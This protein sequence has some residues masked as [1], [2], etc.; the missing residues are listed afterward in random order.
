MKATARQKFAERAAVEL[1]F[2]VNGHQQHRHGCNGAGGEGAQQCQAKNAAAAP[3]MEFLFPCHV[4]E[5]EI[6]CQ[7]Q[8]ELVNARLPENAEIPVPDH[9]FRHK[10]Q[11]II[12]KFA[13]VGIGKDRRRQ[14]AP[15]RQRPQRKSRQGINGKNCHYDAEAFSGL[16]TGDKIGEEYPQQDAQQDAEIHHLPVPLYA[17]GDEDGSSEQQCQQNTVVQDD[18]QKVPALV[19]QKHRQGRQ[20]NAQTEKLCLIKAQQIV[21]Y[22]ADPAEIEDQKQIQPEKYLIGW[23]LGKRKSI[24]H[25]SSRR[26]SATMA[27][28]RCS[29]PRGTATPPWASATSWQAVP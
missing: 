12:V 6:Q 3:H 27:E 7:E 16:G 4:V 25:I 10:S 15:V 19:N 24:G 8:E 14:D 1:F 11:N 20:G 22:L 2:K 17:H 21:G 29:A 28:A 23:F 13:A 18:L 5:A 9:G 26:I